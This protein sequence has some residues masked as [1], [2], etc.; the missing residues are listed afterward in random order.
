MMRISRAAIIFTTLTLVASAIAG[1]GTDKAT[2]TVFTEKEQIEAVRSLVDRVTGGRSSE[3]ELRLLPERQDSLDYFEFSAENGKIVLGG[4]N[5]VSIASALGHYLR[6]YCGFHRSWCGNSSALP[7][8][9]PLPEEKTAKTSPYKW[10]Y[11][12]NYC[13]FNYS[14]SW[15]D[16]DRWQQEIDWMALNGINMPLALTGQNSVWKRVYNKLGFSDSELE[17]FFSGPAYYNWFWMGNLDGW[18][19]PL[20]QSCMKKQEKLAKKILYAERSLGM[21]PVLPAFTGHVPPAFKDKFPEAKISTGSWV[22]FPE[23][24]VLDP[25]EEM[26]TEIGRLFIEEQTRIYGTNH[27]YSADT[28]NENRPQT[29]DTSYLSAISSKLFNSMRAADPKAVWLMQGWLFYHERDYWHEPQIQA[30]L[31]AVPDDGMVILD[32]WS[33]RHPVWERTEAYYGKPWIWCMLQNF[34]QNIVLSG[35][36][37]RVANDPASTLTRPERG[38]FSGIGL[39]MEGINQNP[40]IF[41]LMLENVWRDSPIEIDSFIKNYLSE[42]YG[43]ENED[44]QKAWE[45]IFSTAYENTTNNGGHESIIT[46]R[47][48]FKINPGGTTN[49]KKCYRS[50]ELVAAWKKLLSCCDALSSSDGF[51]YDIVDLT[52][53]VLADY[54]S[55]LQQNAARAFKNGDIQAYKTASGEFLTLIDELEKLLGTREEFLLGRWLGD[56]RRMGKTQEE[57]NLYEHNARNLIGCWGDRNCRIKDYACRQWN[58]MMS[59]YYHKRWE[60]FF[61][62]TISSL[63]KGE[64][65]DFKAFEER[66]KDVEWEWTFSNEKYPEEAV[67]DEIEACKRIMEIYGEKLDELADNKEYKAAEKAYV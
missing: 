25:G 45:I 61:N 38:K 37:S 3:F 60:M 36:A 54:A 21:T 33:E 35:N 34:G 67:G 13:T 47:P 30:L 57:K 7:E 1:C 9:L 50:E 55:V 10:R 62:E 11:Y 23:V 26:F 59:G 40:A 24:S 64:E 16:F 41:A 5:G 65:F 58:G 51:R 8:K 2:Q 43:Q 27:I 53:Q 18:G 20:P 52:R 48:N 56:A 22:N 44:A 19:G 46:G 63:E 31:G 66:C 28:F 15:W 32:L 39:T 42:R 49:T 12:L 17:S 29:S 6:E 4:N 14:M